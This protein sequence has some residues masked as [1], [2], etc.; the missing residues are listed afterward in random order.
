MSSA[1]A[2]T[3]PSALRA[4]GRGRHMLGWLQEAVLLL[5]VVLAI[6]VAILLVG[7]PLAVV[8]QLLIEIARR[9]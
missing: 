3:P 9:W 8:V 4:A 7:A 5:L 1:L 6:P 2:A